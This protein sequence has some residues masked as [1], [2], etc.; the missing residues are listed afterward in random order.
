MR[1]GGGTRGRASSRDA[2]W[3]AC[4]GGDVAC[5]TLRTCIHGCRHCGSRPLKEVFGHGNFDCFFQC[6]IAFHISLYMHYC[7]M[8]RTFSRVL[9]GTKSVGEKNPICDV[10]LKIMPKLVLWDQMAK[11]GVVNAGY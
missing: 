10:S 8:D 3:V 9:Y 7:P 4:L 5:A 1:G 6:S 11:A 2:C